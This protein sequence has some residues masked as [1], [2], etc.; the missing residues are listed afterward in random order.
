M[1]TNLAGNG[2]QHEHHTTRHLRPEGNE[3]GRK[4]EEYWEEDNEHLRKQW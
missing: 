4:V 2:I 3:G 1:S